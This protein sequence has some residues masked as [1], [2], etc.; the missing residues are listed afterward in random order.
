LAAAD[1][2]KTATDPGA[3]FIGMKRHEMVGRVTPVHAV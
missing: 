3:V 2:T 1:C